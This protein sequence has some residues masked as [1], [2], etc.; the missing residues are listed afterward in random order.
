MTSKHTPGPWQMTFTPSDHYQV[1]TIE[2][3]MLADLNHCPNAANNAAI[4]AAAPELYRMLRWITRCASI[5]GPAGA[6]AYFISDDI[7][8]PARSLIDYLDIAQKNQLQEKQIIMTFHNCD[9]C[10]Y[11]EITEENINPTCNWTIYCRKDDRYI[12]ESSHNY[13]LL[14]RPD[15]PIGIEIPNWCPLEDHN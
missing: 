9:D 6:T 4:M 8:E 3:N 12:E 14:V 7:M 13:N 5:T 2:G 15:F 10:P 11:V 1:D